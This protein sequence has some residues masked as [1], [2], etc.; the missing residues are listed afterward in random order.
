M[1]CEMVCVYLQTG[2]FFIECGAF[3]GERASNTI[4]L[5]LVRNWTGLL[6]E[7]DPYF[8][9]QMLGKNRQVWSANVCLSPS[10]SLTKVGL[11][12]SAVFL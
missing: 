8:Y 9:T 12:H 1:M 2:G 6:V 3:D 11:L 7:M 4:W 10:R 5:E